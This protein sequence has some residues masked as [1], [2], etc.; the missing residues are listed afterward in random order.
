QTFG[1]K[2]WVSRTL[3]AKLLKDDGEFAL[4]DVKKGVKH[5]GKPGSTEMVTTKVE[6][7][8]VEAA[9]KTMNVPW[10]LL[11][12]NNPGNLPKGYIWQEIT[13]TVD[14]EIK[15][16]ELLWTDYASDGS[17]IFYKRIYYID[18]ITQRPQKIES[19]TMNNLSQVYELKR[20]TEISYPSLEQVRVTFEKYGY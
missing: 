5:I 15:T 17:P 2:I 11:P 3:G 18:G 4:W 14:Q 19:S 7:D 12:C 9:K 1:Q 10:G 20:I 8:L 16:Y 13:D 6:S